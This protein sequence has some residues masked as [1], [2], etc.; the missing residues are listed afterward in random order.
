MVTRLPTGNEVATM[1]SE[2]D[3]GSVQVREAARPRTGRL[4]AAER[5]AK[6]YSYTNNWPPE[7]LI[8]NGPTA[9]VVARNPRH[10]SNRDTRA[11]P[12]EGNRSGNAH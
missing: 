10:P 1:A 6:D 8:D 11:A 2:N 9:D 4:M 12:A 3:R 5:P 7:A